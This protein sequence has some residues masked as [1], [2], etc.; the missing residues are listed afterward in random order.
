MHP[1][2]PAFCLTAA[3]P[4]LNEC[5]FQ[6]GSQFNSSQPLNIIREHA[7]GVA[8]DDDLMPASSSTVCSD[9]FPLLGRPKS[10]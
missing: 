3:L 1:C 9:A 8:T 7:H 5:V 2:R 6:T 10:L 4:K